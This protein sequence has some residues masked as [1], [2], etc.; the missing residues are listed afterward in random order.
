M[1]H[2]DVEYVGYTPT[3]CPAWELLINKRE[4]EYDPRQ[5]IDLYKSS[6]KLRV[7]SFEQLVGSSM[8]GSWR[9]D[10]YARRLRETFNRAEILIIIRRQ[11]DAI[12]SMILQWVRG[13]GSGRLGIDDFF[14]TSKLNYGGIGFAWDFYEYT[15]TIEYYINLFKQENVR[16]FL[17]EQFVEDK[18]AF[19]NTLNEQ[20]G[21]AEL[22]NIDLRP[23]KQS[24]TPFG[25][26][27]M[28]VVN[29]YRFGWF[30]M[31]QGA[32]DKLRVAKARNRL[33]SLYRKYPVFGRN[34]RFL[35]DDRI[36]E[37]R[38]YYKNDNKKLSDLLQLPLQNY[39][40]AV[41]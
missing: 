13:G 34:F 33:D 31:K 4:S 24:L 18:K 25:Y 23:K 6:K 5:V 38:D 37:I 21:L 17:F 39:G 11:E 7:L 19:L 28:R 16:V 22:D 15:K 41:R 14:R 29:R 36:R 8:F 1:P 3:D 40:Y 10:F 30:N 9:G 32:F 20:Y 2:P 35:S 26:A 12:Q 27:Y